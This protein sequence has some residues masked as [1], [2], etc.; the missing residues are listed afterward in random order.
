MSDAR[1]Y[2]RCDRFNTVYNNAF[3]TTL[4]NANERNYIEGI[5]TYLVDGL[6]ILRSELGCNEAKIESEYVFIEEHR[7]PRA[8]AAADAFSQMHFVRARTPIGRIGDTSH[9]RSGFSFLY[10]NV[11]KCTPRVRDGVL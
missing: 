4:L 1:I 11:V 2:Y 3:S 10:F 8:A 7:E 5:R 6:T 9:T